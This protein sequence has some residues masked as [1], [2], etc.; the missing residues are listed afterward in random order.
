MKIGDKHSVDIVNDSQITNHQSRMASQLISID[1]LLLLL[2]CSFS[3]LATAIPV[4]RPGLEPIR[5]LVTF[6]APQTHYLEVE[7]VVPVDRQP[8]VELM[9]P[10]WTPGSYMVREFARHVEGFTARDGQGRSLEVEKTRKNRWRVS[11][12]KA[13]AI[14]VNYRLYA[15]EMSVRTN[16]VDDRFAL[17]NGAATF[18]TLV[19]RRAR[20]HEV[21]LVLPSGWKQTMTGTA[22]SATWA[23]APLPGTGFRHARRFADRGGKSCGVSIPG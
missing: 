21:R 12:G 4:A 14:T 5:Y 9:M 6:T 2:A 10:V 17:L 16:W 11:T 3:L 23:G 8:H 18:I 15:H 7:A 22:G 19:E 13:A 20:P 1:D